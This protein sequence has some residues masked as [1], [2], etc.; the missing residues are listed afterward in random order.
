MFPIRRYIS[1]N[2]CKTCIHFKKP[3]ASSGD[4][5]PLCTR[6]YVPDKTD[7]VNGPPAYSY[8]HTERNDIVGQ[9]GKNGVHYEPV[10]YWNRVKASA[11]G[12]VAYFG[13]IP[14]LL[15]YYPTGLNMWIYEE[16]VASCVGIGLLSSLTFNGLSHALNDSDYNKTK[17]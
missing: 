4:D 13:S 9:C 12:L 5:L 10:K 8:C 11:C 17:K 7:L 6:V 1:S 15:A 3:L 2:L 16:T 14:V